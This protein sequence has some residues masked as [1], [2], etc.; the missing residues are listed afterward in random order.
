MKYLIYLIILSFISCVDCVCPARYSYARWYSIRIGMDSQT[1]KN[2]LGEPSRRLK[3][4]DT[5]DLMM[6]PI[7]IYKRDSVENVGEF[8]L[9]RSAKY[10][11]W[12]ENWQVQEIEEDNSTESFTLAK[13]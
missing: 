5:L 11:N 9:C 12:D 3:P 6:P 7:W 10:I 1:V 13:D 2:I 8:C 4:L